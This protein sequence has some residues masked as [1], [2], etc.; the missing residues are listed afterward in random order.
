MITL[1]LALYFL[2]NFRGIKRAAC[3]LVPRS[4]RALLGIVGALLAVP[5]AAALQL[6]AT[7]V[8]MPRQEGV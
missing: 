3:R 8:V 5:I 6:V 2:A 4:R 7:E 1:V